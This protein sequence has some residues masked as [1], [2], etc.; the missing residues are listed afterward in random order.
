MVTRR[1][2]TAS[3]RLGPAGAGP[4]AVSGV[5]VQAP[6]GWVGAVAR[7]GRIVAMCLPMPTRDAAAS[8]CGR[9]A[10]FGPPDDL[11]ASLADDLRRYFAG[12][13][14][15]L[16]RYPVD[17]SEHPPF[18]RH[19]LLAARTIRY[20]EVR[21]YAWVAQRAGRPRGARAAGQAMSRNPIPLAI[22]CHRVVATG[23]G[24]GGFGGG[25]AMKRALLAL[26]GIACDSRGVLDG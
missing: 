16:G 25:L 22:P 20:G 26:E 15:D 1:R 12:E 3:P 4:D 7:D 2:S 9:D 13:T 21:T 17:I 11:L 10:D 24:L 5:V 14:V 8:A 19:A 18:R 23:G 6:L